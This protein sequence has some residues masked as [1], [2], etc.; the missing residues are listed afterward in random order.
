MRKQKKNG[1]KAGPKELLSTKAGPKELLSTKAGTATSSP[2]N[3]GGTSA[4]KP[5]ST[6]RRNPRNLD[7]VTFF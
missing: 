2:R 6:V 1:K 4:I 3:S 5:L 7:Y